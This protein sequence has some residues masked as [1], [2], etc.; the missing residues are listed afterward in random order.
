MPGQVRPPQCQ[1]PSNAT[2]PQSGLFYANV[3][4]LYQD[5]C[6]I[7]HNEKIQH[8]HGG[9]EDHKSQQALQQV[10]PCVKLYI[11][12]ASYPVQSE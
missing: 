4:F 5:I 12:L 7:N 1:T 10:C 2:D 6:V 3:P 8:H 11:H 9:Q